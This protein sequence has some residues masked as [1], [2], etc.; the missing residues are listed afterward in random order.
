[1][2]VFDKMR[3]TQAAPYPVLYFPWLLRSAI[4]EWLIISV[5]FQDLINLK[6][7]RF[8]GMTHTPKERR[9]EDRT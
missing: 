8:A 7:D 6:H 4:L 9:N 5:P 1:M 2:D 3:K